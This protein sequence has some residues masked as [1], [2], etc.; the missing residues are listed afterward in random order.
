MIFTTHTVFLL[1][2]GLGITKGIDSINISNQACILRCWWDSTLIRISTRFSVI[3]RVIASEYH[4]FEL[5][6]FVHVLNLFK[7]FDFCITSSW[8]CSLGELSTSVD[9]KWMTIFR[10]PFHHGYIELR[11][12]DKLSINRTSDFLFK[13]S[14]FLS[15]I[16]NGLVL[17]GD[18]EET[19]VGNE[20]N[21]DTD[22]KYKAHETCTR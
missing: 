3:V 8:G 7:V 18:I 20:N 11:A 6:I 12:L 16:E 22:G 19:F 1:S 15:I 21:Q 5:M 4:L 14:W 9:H 2:I 17:L 13:W 10:S